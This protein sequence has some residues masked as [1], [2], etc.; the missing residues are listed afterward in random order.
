MYGELKADSRHGGLGGLRFERRRSVRCER[1][2]AECGIQGIHLS[3]HRRSRSSIPPVPPPEL[4]F[5][6]LPTRVVR[7]GQTKPWIGLVLRCEGGFVWG[8]EGVV[9]VVFKGREGHCKELPHN[10]PFHILRDHHL[11]IKKCH[12][13]TPTPSG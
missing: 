2:L 11:I 6:V 4:P 9:G 1:S 10:H 8:G 13:P 7:D 3:T 12:P 5:P